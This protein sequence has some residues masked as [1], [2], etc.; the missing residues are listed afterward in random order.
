MIINPGG[1]GQPRD[2][3]PRSAYMVLD[4]PDNATLAD[5]DWTA[6]LTFWRV[7]YPIAEIQEIMRDLSF[8]PRLIS[9]LELGLKKDEKPKEGLRPVFRFSVFVLVMFL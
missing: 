3:D 5:W 9:R 2:G 8:P 7:E 4:I 1:V 6:T